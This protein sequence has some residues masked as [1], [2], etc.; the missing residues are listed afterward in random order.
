MLVLGLFALDFDWGRV[1]IRR[2]CDYGRKRLI[3]EGR[4]VLRSGGAFCALTLVLDNLSYLRLE[5]S[6]QTLLLLLRSC[7]RGALNT[8]IQAQWVAGEVCA[9]IVT[10]AD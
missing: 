5:F 4:I 9:L 2:F 8:S 10:A 3:G 7:G 1:S 6:E